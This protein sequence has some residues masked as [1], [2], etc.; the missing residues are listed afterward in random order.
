M[1]WLATAWAALKG[2]PKLTDD[3]FDK[4]EGI[5]VKAGGFIDGLHHSSQEKAQDHQKMSQLVL[6]HVKATADESTVKSKT[7]REL[8]VKWINVQLYLVMLT[9]ICVPAAIIFPDQGVPMFTMYLKLTI[10]YLMVGG[11][12]TVMAYFFGTYGW[13]TYISKKGGK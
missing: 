8:A 1:N 6:D 3:I 5:L 4:N 7:R 12:I 11:T 2:T 9:A 10:S 13:G